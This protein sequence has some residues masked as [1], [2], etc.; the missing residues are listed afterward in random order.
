MRLELERLRG[1]AAA[2]AGRRAQFGERVPHEESLRRD[3]EFLEGVIDG[4]P[5]GIFAHDRDGHCRVWNTA[6]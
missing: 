4:S 6:L 5:A 2:R 3:E 1:E